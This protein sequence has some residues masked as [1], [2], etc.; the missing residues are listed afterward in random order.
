[1]WFVIIVEPAHPEM[2]G[3]E[4]ELS[5]TDQINDLVGPFLTF[6]EAEGWAKL[7]EAGAAFEQFRYLLKEPVAPSATLRE[8]KR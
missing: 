5:V 7:H 1:M 6:E 3:S 8:L 4:A 2:G